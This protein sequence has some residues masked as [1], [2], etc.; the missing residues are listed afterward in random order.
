MGHILAEVITHHGQE[1]QQGV[2]RGLMLKGVSINVQHIAEEALLIKEACKGA[3]NLKHELGCYDVK[4]H[5]PQQMAAVDQFEDLIGRDAALE[6]IMPN[7]AVNFVDKQSSLL[8]LPGILAIP[9]KE[10]VVV[11][12][13]LS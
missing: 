6:N 12:L 11:I 5:T 2:N 8:Q 10:R 4:T 1:I 13:D 9:P 3:I 7:N